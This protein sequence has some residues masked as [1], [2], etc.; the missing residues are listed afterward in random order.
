[1]FL[2]K[3]LGSELSDDQIWY[4]KG[5]VNFSYQDPNGNLSFLDTHVTRGLDVFGASSKDSINLSRDGGSGDFTKAETILSRIQKIGNDF[6][7]Q[8]SFSAQVASR[9][10]LSSEEFGYGGGTF[11]R[12]YDS[13]EISGD[14]GM[15]GLAELRYQSLPNVGN[16]LHMTPF[17][18]YDAGKV[19][20]KN[21]G[22]ETNISGTSAGFGSY[23]DA[24][25]GVQGSVTL[26]KPLTRNID[27]PLR[28]DGD[29]W[30]VRF[31]LGITY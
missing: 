2:Q 5:G 27:A 30:Q 1:M 6:A 18:F 4:L 21:D 11:G 20:N 28:G 26:A 24:I 9:S 14:S 19:W 12:A 29:D 10:L 13:S 16:A 31:E 7:L 8:T 23:I 22:Q 15:A 17:V 3:F 25:Y